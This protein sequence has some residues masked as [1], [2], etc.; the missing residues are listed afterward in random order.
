M[1]APEDASSGTAHSASYCPDDPQKCETKTGVQEK[2]RV[3]LEGNV[4]SRLRQV[5]H[6]QKIGSVAGKY[7]SEGLNE[8]GARV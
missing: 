6:Q 7:S 8:I 4:A 1:P 3:G 2:S 5:G